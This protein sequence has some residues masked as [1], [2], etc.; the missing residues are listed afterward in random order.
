MAGRFV[1]LECGILDLSLKKEKFPGTTTSSEG[2]GFLGS[3][4]NFPEAI[5][6]SFVSRGVYGSFIQV[7]SELFVLDGIISPELDMEID[8]KYP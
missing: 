8:Q 7:Y 2:I 3:M 6:L 1:Q 4:I 5:Q